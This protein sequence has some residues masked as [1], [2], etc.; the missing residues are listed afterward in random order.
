[1]ALTVIEI[2]REQSLLRKT[3]FQTTSLLWSRLGG[4]RLWQIVVL[5]A[6]ARNFESDIQLQQINVMRGGLN[7]PSQQMQ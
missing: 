6:A 7:C 2:E 3:D 1:M 4:Q 5:V